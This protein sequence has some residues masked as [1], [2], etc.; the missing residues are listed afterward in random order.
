MGL[1][2]ASRIAGESLVRPAADGLVR[3]VAVAARDRAV[4]FAAENNIER[5]VSYVYGDMAHPDGEFSPRAEGDQEMIDECY[6]R[7]GLPPSST[8]RTG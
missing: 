8:T 1:L 4:K 2:G 5:A 3:L 6:R 7:A